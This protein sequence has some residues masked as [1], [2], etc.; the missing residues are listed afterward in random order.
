MSKQTAWPRVRHVRTYDE[1]ASYLRD[2]VGDVYPFL[3]IH[4][5]PGVSKT[6]SIQAAISGRIAFYRAG[7]QLTPLQLYL[8]C[9][10]H[11][12]QPIILDDCTALLN[13]RVGRRLISALG[14]TSAEKRLSYGSTTHLL[15]TYTAEGVP[16]EFTT[17]SALC[18]V[19]NEPTR[20]PEI[21]SRAVNLHFDP[22]A[23]ELHRAVAAWFHDQE[24]FDWFGRH[25][26][27]LPSLSMRDY[28]H[29]GQ[30]KTA[31]RDWRRIAATSLAGQYTPEII[32][33]DLE[34]DAAYPS[35]EAKAARFAEL[36]GGARGASRASYFRKRSD[37]E[38]AGRLVVPAIGPIRVRGVRPSAAPPAPD[39]EATG[40]PPDVP[41]VQSPPTDVSTRETFTEPIRGQTPGTVSPPS[42]H[43]DDRLPW[44]PPESEGAD[45][46]E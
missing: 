29:A 7:G 38:A 1:F 32:M 4:G 18:I 44:E 30:D 35:R 39:A 42:M 9:F 16:D 33:L 36:M 13:D 17:R 2:F 14:D 24:I 3:W 34:V 23:E 20:H 6:E 26:Q 21:Q 46:E 25:L 15:E 11:L 41:E 27:R 28:V 19:T 40:P 12:N 10:E 8:D 45:E 31:G 5:R 43:L 22:T 37:L